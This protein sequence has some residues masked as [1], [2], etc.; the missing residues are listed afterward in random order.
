MMSD[1]SR[2]SDAELYAMLGGENALREKAFGELYA[3]YSS[4]IYLYCTKILGRNGGV[5]DAFQQT[6]LRFLQSAQSDRLMTNVPAYLLRIAR[7]LCLNQRKRAGQHTVPLEEF[8]LPVEDTSLEAKELERL[9]AMALE[10]LPDDQ[11][12]VF[13]LQAY[14]GLSYKEIGEVIDAPITTVRNRIVRAKR[15]VREILSPYLED[16]RP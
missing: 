5:E 2:H 15:R 14:S 11:R 6:F 1:I 9:V 16:Y 7:N 12:E 13:I 8:H 3:R 10:L 4:K